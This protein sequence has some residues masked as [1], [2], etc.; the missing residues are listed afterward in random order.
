MRKQVDQILEHVIA[1]AMGI[2]D[3]QHRLGRASGDSS[4]AIL[5][6]VKQV[7]GRIDI[8]AKLYRRLTDERLDLQRSEGQ[9][10]D[11]PA[12]LQTSMQMPQQLGLTRSGMAGEEHHRGVLGNRLQ[13][14]GTRR[15]ELQT[16]VDMP[17]VCELLKRDVL[18]TEVIRIHGPVLRPSG[19]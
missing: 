10:E 8:D 4:Q 6:A 12:R 7:L 2:I 3:Q 9:I 16:H 17:W 13:H 11:R 1:E 14:L 5:K 15:L 19:S 18:K